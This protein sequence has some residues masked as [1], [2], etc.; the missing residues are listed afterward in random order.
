MTAADFKKHI[1]LLTDPLLSSA[2]MFC[3]AVLSLPHLWDI[4]A[5]EMNLMKTTWWNSRMVLCSD[6]KHRTCLAVCLRD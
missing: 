5:V 3:V 2:H 1:F 6:S 4:L